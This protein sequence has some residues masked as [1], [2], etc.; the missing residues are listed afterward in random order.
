MTATNQSTYV[1]DNLIEASAEKIGQP[2]EHREG[3]AAPFSNSNAA[4]VIAPMT[5]KQIGEHASAFAARCKRMVLAD[6][7]A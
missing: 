7:Q 2:I 6:P 4:G 5:F 1:F 3:T